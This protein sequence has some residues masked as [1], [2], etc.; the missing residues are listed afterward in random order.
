MTS[1]GGHNASQTIE[2]RVRY[3]EVDAM[4]VLHHSRYWVY[5][6]M[7]RTE[8]LRSMGVAYRD[9]EASGILFVVARLSVRYHRS[10]R[11]DDVLRLH[12]S[13]A[14]SHGVKVEHEYQMFRG[15]ELLAT[16]ATTIVCLDRQG[17]LRPVPPELTITAST[18]SVS[19]SAP[20]S[21]SSTPPPPPS[22]VS[23]PLSPE[24]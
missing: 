1:T 2:I 20:P 16:G 4:G 15:E 8:L 3:A 13:M 18:R 19:V 5:F 23:S 17:K 9:L 14:Q 24:I 10:A 21:R 11:Y 22:I 7:G 6:E 12:V